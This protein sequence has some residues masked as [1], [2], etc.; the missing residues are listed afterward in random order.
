MFKKYL[1]LSKLNKSE[2]KQLEQILGAEKLQRKVSRTNFEVIETP[3]RGGVNI[4]AN[5]GKVFFVDFQNLP[6]YLPKSTI[7][8]LVNQG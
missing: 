2:L 4:I 3:K 6:K 7:A 5:N 1:D 8:K